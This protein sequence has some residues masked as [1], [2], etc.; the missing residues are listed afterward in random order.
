MRQANAN[1]ITYRG[2]HYTSYEATQRQRSLEA[3]IRRQ[4]R[5]I[6][7]DEA[8]G[9]AEQMQPDQ[10]K[11]QLLNQ[12]YK[13]FSKAAGLR[14]QDERMEV[15]GYNW[16]H[17]R[18]AEK[19]GLNASAQNYKLVT[20]GKSESFLTRSGERIAAQSVNG[21]DRVFVSDKAFIKSKALHNINKNTVETMKKWEIAADRKP[22]VVIVSREEMPTALG[23]YDPVENVV[24]Y[25]PNISDKCVMESIGGLGVVE[26]H[27]MWHLKQA[28]DFRKTV[29]IIT[30]ENQGEYLTRLCE[31]CKIHIDKLGITRDNVEEISQ[32]AQQMYFKGRYDE[33]EAEYNAMRRKKG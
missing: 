30:R 3:S 10:I 19:A 18:A 24:Y 33:V 14:M 28:E 6:L 2:K 7:V 12:E 8:T 23:K 29:W 15:V 17:E 21:Y 1:G 13:R 25:A 20:Y 27:E 16:R 5:K 31:K 22:K 32:Y 11:L 26:Y 4:R 9:D